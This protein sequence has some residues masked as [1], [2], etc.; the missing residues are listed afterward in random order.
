MDSVDQEGR[1]L[2]PV[3]V[4][5]DIVDGRAALYDVDEVLGP[6]LGSRIAFRVR[7]ADMGRE[8]LSV[9]LAKDGRETPGSTRPDD[10]VGRGGREGDGAVYGRVERADGC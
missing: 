3:P 2:S 6:A 5:V 9:R 1:L 7:R 10:D 4:K 8:R